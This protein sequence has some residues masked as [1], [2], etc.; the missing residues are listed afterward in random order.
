M[1]LKTKV[2][3]CIFFFLAMQGIL[4]LLHRHEEVNSRVSAGSH[5]VDLSSSE[6]SPGSELSIKDQGVDS[7][8]PAKG[9]DSIPELSDEDQGV[10]FP[11]NNL[12]V[13]RA[14]FKFGSKISLEG[15]DEKSLYKIPDN[16]NGRDPLED[17]SSEIIKKI[18]PR[19]D[20]KKYNKEFIEYINKISIQ[21]TKLW[22]RIPL[23]S[24]RYIDIDN[25]G[26][27]EYFVISNGMNDDLWGF[28]DFIVILKKKVIGMKVFDKWE[29]MF[30]HIIDENPYHE[31]SSDGG[32]KGFS[33]FELAINDLDKDGRSDI[34]FTTMLLGGSA[35]ARFIN[36]ISIHPD[37][38]IRY[39]K[40]WSREKVKI[41]DKKSLRPVF[42]QYGD[43][44]FGCPGDC[45]MTVRNRGYRKAYYH[46]TVNDGFVRF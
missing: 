4:K 27:L 9:Q 44:Y 33:E 42:I 37:M 17:V 26:L 12:E 16:T 15:L 8:L 34:I 41:M 30:F 25:D 3:L 14:E 45:G 22:E 28:N 24:R 29:I 21:Y 13:L 39:H 40:L 38:K 10:D 35:H 43:D 2:L 36:I 19:L 7:K 18:D 31:Y 6:Q 1:K 5:S 32:S 23:K 46:W 11:F 20:G